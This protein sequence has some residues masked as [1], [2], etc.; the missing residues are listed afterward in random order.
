MTLTFCKRFP[1]RSI[2]SR[3]QALIPANKRLYGN[4]LR[5]GKCQVLQRPPFALLASVVSDPVRTVP[6]P[7]ELSGL[8]VQ[9]F[10]NSFKLL[11]GYFSAQAEQLRPTS[12]PLTLNAAVLIVIV[13][14]FKMPLGI[15]GAA[16]H[17]SNRQHRQTLTLFEITKQHGHFFVP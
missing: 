16:R 1:N 11:L 13:A 17:G 6:R 12:M 5:G 4:R 9:P 8:R 2:V 7:K 10:T 15:P 3:N 14:V